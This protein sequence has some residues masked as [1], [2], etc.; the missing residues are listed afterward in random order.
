MFNRLQVEY[1]S[2]SASSSDLNLLL[3]ASRLFLLSAYDSNYF[4]NNFIP[5]SNS[6]DFFL[7]F[8]FCCCSVARSRF[9]YHLHPILLVVAQAYLDFISWLF[10]CDN[11]FLSPLLV[12]PSIRLSL[13]LLARFYTM[14]SFL[15]CKAEKKERLWANVWKED[16]QPLSESSFVG[17]H[18][19]NEKRGAEDERKKVDFTRRS[20][21]Y[22]L[23]ARAAE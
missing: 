7:F 8:L 10:L 1:Q 17:C 19:K 18:H 14:F 5:F 13:I 21:A 16:L 20:D 4:S 11:E 2:L 9:F 15:L 6:L 12:V 22:H 3:F 23:R